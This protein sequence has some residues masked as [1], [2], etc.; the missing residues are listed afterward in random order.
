M[1]GN[2]AMQACQNNGLICRA[3]AGS[4]LAFCPPLIV[5][6]AQIDEMIE[7]I[8]KSLKQTLNFANH[9]GLLAK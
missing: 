1:V 7:K 4:S 9:K 6:K 2:F 8:A 3:I 5:T